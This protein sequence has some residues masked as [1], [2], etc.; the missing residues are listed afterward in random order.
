MA[1]RISIAQS[2]VKPL[3]HTALQRRGFT[4]FEERGL[5][6]NQSLEF[7]VR[8]NPQSRVSSRTE[9]HRVKLTNTLFHITA[10]CSRRG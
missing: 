1:T 9:K 8:H 7:F 10:S 6:I 3:H 5:V 2:A 4:C